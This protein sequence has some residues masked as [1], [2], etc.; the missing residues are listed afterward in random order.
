METL[1]ATMKLSSAVMLAARE[2]TSRLFIIDA[3]HEVWHRG[4]AGF[5]CF[6]GKG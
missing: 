5:K 4:I 3:G 1:R 2:S 6:A